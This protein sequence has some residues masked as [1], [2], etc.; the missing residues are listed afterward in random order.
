MGH[1][2]FEPL[3]FC[4]EGAG[5]GAHAVFGPKARQENSLGERFD[6]FAVRVKPALV[7]TEII[8]RAEI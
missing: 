3:A 1:I 4:A 5:F 6:R 8:H 7:I 2:V